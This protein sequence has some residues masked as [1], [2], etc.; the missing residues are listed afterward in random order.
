MTPKANSVPTALVGL[1]SST[2]PWTM[3]EHL[4]RIETMGQ[5]I[6]GYIQF[7]R[8]VGSMN[9][10]SGE[11]KERA[12]KAFY[13]RMLALESQLSRIQDNLRLE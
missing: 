11:A 3:E 12:V 1:C 5:R 9:G 8:Q 13:E 7:M 2:P 10:T 4:E 6:N